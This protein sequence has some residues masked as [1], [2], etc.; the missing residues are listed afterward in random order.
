VQQPAD[1]LRLRLGVVTGGAGQQFLER[2][3]AQFTR[4]DNYDQ[5]LQAVDE[6]RIDA[7]VG[8]LPSLRY[9]VRQHWQGILEVSPLLLEPE[10]FAIAL[11]ENS[12][13]RKKLDSAIIRARQGEQWR[14]IVHAH[15]GSF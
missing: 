6:K 9:L 5:A 13:L 12:P 2:R 8:N 10:S 14:D 3:H 7:F 4:F 1:L 15:L 11:P